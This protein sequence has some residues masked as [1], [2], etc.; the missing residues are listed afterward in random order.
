MK[1][2][3]KPLIITR[4]VQL[5]NMMAGSNDPINILNG[6]IGS[7]DSGDAPTSADVRGRRGTWGDL[8]A[9]DEE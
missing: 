1:T 7:N 6:D 4:N 3:Q 8:W 2:Y 5:S 9:E